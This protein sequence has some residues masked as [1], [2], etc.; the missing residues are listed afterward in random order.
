MSAER[1]NPAS[2]QNNEGQGF[3]TGPSNERVEEPKITQQ[4]TQEGG[5]PYDMSSFFD[6]AFQRLLKGAET[7]TDRRDIAGEEYRA[8]KGA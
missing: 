5:K 8:P 7:Y 1:F 3:S 4:Q 6:P 2:R